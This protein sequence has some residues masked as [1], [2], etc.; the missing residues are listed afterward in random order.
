MCRKPSEQ[1]VV[2]DANIARTVTID[3]YITL[4]RFKPWQVSRCAHSKF[5]R[6]SLHGH[7][8]ELAKSCEEVGSTPYSPMRVGA[9]Y[10][11]HQPKGGYSREDAISVK[12]I[13]NLLRGRTH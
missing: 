7:W 1:C 8:R 12:I 5:L 13:L 2:V 4:S 10:R 3:L 9:M 11:R 6:P